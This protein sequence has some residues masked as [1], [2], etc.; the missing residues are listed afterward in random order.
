MARNNQ[1]ISVDQ[2]DSAI[3]E[4]VAEFLEDC[5]E[6]VNEAIT[7]A[8]KIAVNSLKKT[9][10]PGAG[11]YRDW[12]E[13]Q[14]GWRRTT[15]KNV[16]GDVTVTIHNAKKPGLTHLLEKGHVLQDGTRARAFPHVEPAAEE[17]IEYLE[18]KLNHGL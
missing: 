2:L 7:E 15:K 16:L 5:E 10:P 12:G 6:D 14:K 8:G 13:Y 9:T 1:R 3:C 11:K 4:I 17:A 18:E